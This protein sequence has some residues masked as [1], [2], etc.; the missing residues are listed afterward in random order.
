MGIRVWIE[1]D[2]ERVAANLIS[3]ADVVTRWNSDKAYRHN[4]VQY[5]EAIHVGPVPRGAFARAFIVGK[6]DSEIRLLSV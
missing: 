3:A 1:I 4:F 5:I 6:S 2:R